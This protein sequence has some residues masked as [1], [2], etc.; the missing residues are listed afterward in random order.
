MRRIAVFIAALPLAAALVG[1]ASISGGS[2][3]GGAS[4]ATGKRRT[5]FVVPRSEEWRSVARK[6]VDVL[7][8]SGLLKG[9][10]GEKAVVAVGNVKDATWWVVDETLFAR[11]LRLALLR[12]GKALSTSIQPGSGGKGADSALR[13][14]FE[15]DSDIAMRQ[16]QSGGKALPPEFVV[17]LKLTDTRTKR[18]VWKDAVPVAAR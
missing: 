11:S 14:D 2:G 6:C 10:D 15:L 4:S 17:R 8:A 13:P 12:S 5:P 16:R 7:A 1:C 3:G 18:V 9:K